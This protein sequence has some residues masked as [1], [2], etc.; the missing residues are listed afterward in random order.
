[1]AEGTSSTTDSEIKRCFTLLADLHN[2]INRSA[3]NFRKETG[4]LTMASANIRRKSLNQ[5]WIS[6]QEMHQNLI[7]LPELDLNHVYF[8]DNIFEQTE[9][10]YFQSEEIMLNYI[11]A[12]QPQQQINDQDGEN[13]Q[14]I[15][16]INQTPQM[17]I[18]LPAISIQKFSGSYYEWTT[19]YDLFRTMIH[20]RQN[21]SNVQKMHYLKSYLNG[22]AL[23]LI[24]HLQISDA[25]YNTAWELL[26]NRYQNIRLLVSSQISRLMTQPRIQTE[27]SAAIKSL[28]DNTKEVLQSLSN[29]NIDIT[30]WDPMI[31]YIITQRMDSETHRLWEQSLAD[32]KTLSTFADMTK[33]LETRFQSLDMINSLDSINQL[34]RNNSNNYTF[35]NKSKKSIACA[36][37]SSNMHTI[38]R[39][40]K[41]IQMSEYDRLKW[42]QRTSKCTNCF[43]SDHH[44][45][46]CNS[47]SRCNICNKN[48]HTL[49]HLQKQEAK[50]QPRSTCNV[51]RYQE[52]Q[53]V[54][55]QT[56]P[57]FEI[58][59]NNNYQ[60]S[61]N[62]KYH[63]NP[64]KDQSNKIKTTTSNNKDF[65]ITT[66]I[67]TKS[68]HSKLEEF[69]DN[70]QVLLAT[71]IVQILDVYGTRRNLRALIDQGSESNF[72]TEAAA[73]M[74]RLPR[75]SSNI[76]VS[77]I[78]NLQ[79][80]SN[81][82]LNFILSSTQNKNFKSDM[83]ALIISKITKT[84]PSTNVSTTFP[85]LDNLPLADPFYFKP[86]KIDLLI[87]A[88]KYS[89]ILLEGLIKGTIHSPIAQNTEL[90][91]I[92]SGGTG[93]RTNKVSIFH[94]KVEEN[95]DTL[96]RRFWEL[97]EMPKI[98]HFTKEEQL[99]EKIY[100]ETV[101]RNTNGS[102]IVSLPF[103][104]NRSLI[105]GNSR[106]RAIA[107]LI[108]I[109]KSFKKDP[110]LQK[111]YVQF[112]NEYF[113]LNHAK[114]CS[115]LS[116]CE[117]NSDSQYYLPHQAVVRE[118]STTTK[119]RV[120]FDASSK[121]KTGISL[122]DTLMTGPTI[123]S[124]L[125]SIILKWR[126]H[127]YAITADIEKMYRQIHVH[128]DHHNF[129]RIV[130]RNNPS[131]QIKDY[132]LTTVTY[133]TSAAPYLAIKTLQ[134]F[135]TDD[136]FMYPLASKILLSD[137]YVDDLMSGANSEEEK[138][139]IKT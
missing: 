14:R 45:Y 92:I 51:S 81:G 71:A 98:K 15:I 96:L 22:E 117:L 30:S 89:E 88:E 126:T 104:E 56:Y 112:M 67:N 131:D 127:K 129:Q 122:N 1:M 21:L 106:D 12:L 62:A 137:F 19:F 72:I 53:T 40:N 108:S 130:W 34:T 16:Q 8:K 48:H 101:N 84:I 18:K 27:S 78:C 100:E 41:F 11:Q 79:Q 59:N 3:I 115:S 26:L 113:Q 35:S 99:C 69:Q 54:S 103:K 70:Q 23:K 75:K 134:K 82:Q 43:R 136:G 87:G 83:S 6:F 28:L 20:E 94:V 63:Y 55:D 123:Q 32:P 60:C 76:V 116:I 44:V 73:Q 17:E 24:D 118:S 29:L 31:I 109:E 38:F 52:N 124:D 39:C 138:Y 49:L 47:K 36:Y 66:P 50:P 133:G 85:H 125:Y 46:E 90:G 33:F 132:Q 57:L 9:E 102:Y 128:P 37:C 58:S 2:Q 64:F 91:W 97:E 120:V 86:G 65:N 25:N 107:R 7:S 42:A 95:V 111:Q 10:A 77:G 13:I 93:Q 4:R 105:L 139:S 61:S 5:K 114:L 119:L 121:S 68:H 135:A 110:K 74:L 80:S